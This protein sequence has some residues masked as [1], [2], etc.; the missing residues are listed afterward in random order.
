MWPVRYGLF[1]LKRGHYMAVRNEQ[2]RKEGVYVLGG[3]GMGGDCACV[4]GHDR[5]DTLRTSW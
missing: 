5:K 2:T 4:H 3:E 1:L